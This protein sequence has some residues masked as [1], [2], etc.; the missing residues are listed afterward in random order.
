MSDKYRRNLSQRL[1]RKILLGV[2]IS[3]LAILVLGACNS[4]P[5]AVIGSIYGAKPSDALRRL[6]KGEVHALAFSPDNE[7]F[8]V[9][10][11]VG[12]Y[13]HATDSM[14]EL[15]AAP[16]AAGVTALAFDP[17]G[18]VLAVGLENEIL[19]LLNASTG[20]PIPGSP[21]L[22]VGEV[23][24]LTWSPVAKDSQRTLAVGFSD[25]VSSLVGIDISSE[26]EVEILVTLERAQGGV[27]SMAFSPDGETLAVSDSSGELNLWDSVLGQLSL[28]LEGHGRR[29]PITSLLWSSEGAILIS[30]G[31][32]GKIIAWDPLAGSHQHEIQAHGEPVAGLGWVKQESALQ[33]ISTQGSLKTWDSSSLESIGDERVLIGELVDSFWSND[34]RLLLLGSVDESVTLWATQSASGS[35]PLSTLLGFNAPGETASVVAWSMDGDRI[36]ASH[37]ERIYVWDT[38]S[39]E[40]ESED[41]SGFPM[42][43]LS[44]HEGSNTAIAWSPDG[45]SLATGGRD[46]TVI[47]WDSESGD[48]LYRL[49]GHEN[50]IW[51]VVWSPDGLRIASS[52]GLDDSIIIWD[53]Q[54]GKQVGKVPGDTYGLFGLAWSPNGNSLAAGTGYG[55]VLI[56][57][58]SQDEIGEPDASWFGQLSWVGGIA[59][60]PDGSS[61]ASSSAD[62]T[63]VVWDVLQGSKQHTL[64]GHTDA[65]LD[66][67]FEKEGERLASASA[68][69]LVIVWHLD[70][71]SAD[72]F[73]GHTQVVG[74]V[75]W[76]PEGD[77]ASGSADGTVIIWKTSQSD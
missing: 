37:G 74:S 43:I 53:A 70:E 5:E 62:R 49:E 66:V 38:A 14:E 40:N 47:I 3:G 59:W 71:E 9:G 50:T 69:G 57:D 11:E 27:T 63:I 26:P 35:D 30:G 15:W 16:T 33:S 12:L 29:N 45:K 46:R 72:V 41:K 58:V 39:L 10:S 55:R 22:R 67:A 6:G 18:E 68:D 1:N 75:D 23:T 19:I 24:S 36:A 51:S 13:Y 52:G 77:L 34:G 44:G 56:W 73:P 21:A 4:E 32:E 60:S 8:V 76:S 17:G 42:M 48:L 54:S 61:L 28:R 20:Q 2:L 31:G 65:V 25:G 64:T 7:N